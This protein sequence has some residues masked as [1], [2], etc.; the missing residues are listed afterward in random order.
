MSFPLTYWDARNILTAAGQMCLF[1]LAASILPYVFRLQHPKTLL[2]YGRVVLVV[3][4]L[5]PV[6]Q[7]WR[8]ADAAVWT[9]SVEPVLLVEIL[10][11]GIVL[12]V[13]W[14]LVGLIRVHRYRTDAMPLFPS[15]ETITA[16]E[17]LTNANA[18]Y[19]V[20][21]NPQGPVTFGWL[22]PVIVLPEKFLALPEEAQCGIACHELLHV[23]RRDW[24]SSM[25]EEF[26][27]SLQWFNPGTWL[28]LAQ[29]RLAREQVVDQEAVRL[30]A[31]R[32]PY[33]EA[34]LS[35]AKS[36]RSDL[37]PAP[38]FLKRSFPRVCRAKQSC[39]V[40]GRWRVD[41]DVVSRPIVAVDGEDR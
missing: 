8:E 7:P 11:A 14:L 5:I 29:T 1:A 21:T 37:A 15:P 32:E 9:F 18:T 16:A 36:G 41:G 20:S 34:L 2:I 31:S 10:T 35:F 13:V 6:L 33:I 19:C 22:F 12:R 24:L 28:L 39:E 38:S 26:A 17:V 25:L 30:T 27:G 4:F 23:R 40:Y 3:C